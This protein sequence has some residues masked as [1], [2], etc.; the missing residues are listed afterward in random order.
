MIAGR[1][2]AAH[3]MAMALPLQFTKITGLPVAAR[4]LEQFRLLRRQFDARPVPA[5]KAVEIH[6]HLLPFQL[7]ADAAGVNHRVRH[8]RGGDDIRTNALSGLALGRN[9][10]GQAGS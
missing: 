7:R 10:S 4:A 6:P 8:L 2:F 1:C 5:A 3:G 9:A